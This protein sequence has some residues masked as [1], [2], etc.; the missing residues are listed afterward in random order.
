MVKGTEEENEDPHPKNGYADKERDDQ[1]PKRPVVRNEMHGNCKFFS[2]PTEYKWHLR[3]YRQAI[4]EILDEL[5]VRQRFSFPGYQG[6]TG[7]NSGTSGGFV[8]R[9]DD[10]R[11][12]SFDGRKWSAWTA[13]DTGHIDERRREQ[14]A[15]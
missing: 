7:P 11:A 5:H 1:E 2:S 10:N 13:S 3:A 4:C 14:E 9:F 8:D 12:T 6:V 15:I